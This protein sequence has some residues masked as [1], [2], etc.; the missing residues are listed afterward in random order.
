MHVHQFEF[1]ISVEGSRVR[2]IYTM[3]SDNAQTLFL[4]KV[5]L[6]VDRNHYVTYIVHISKGEPDFLS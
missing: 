6:F 3:S 1:H 2:L 4:I 5:C